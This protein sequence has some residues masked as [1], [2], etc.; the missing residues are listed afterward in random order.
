[1]RQALFIVC[2]LAA[3]PL[4]AQTAQEYCEDVRKEIQSQDFPQ[5]LDDQSTLISRSTLYV[6]SRCVVQNVVKV[7]SQALIDSIASDRNSQGIGTHRDSVVESLLSAP[8]RESMID[9]LKESMTQSQA[10]AM[11][12]PGVTVYSTYQTSDP[13]PPFT[14]TLESDSP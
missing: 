1:M 6:Q 4:S 11:N 3:A 12:I 10:P 5:A 9:A 14:I 7:D 8:G 13:I 2:I